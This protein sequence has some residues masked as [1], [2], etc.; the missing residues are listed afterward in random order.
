MDEA[1]GLT[2][3]TR[4]EAE[5]LGIVE[6]LHGPSGTHAAELLGCADVLRESGG[7]VLTEAITRSRGVA[8]APGCR[9]PPANW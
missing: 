7:T 2:V 8:P 9:H 4:D 5:T 3:F 6:P 1:I